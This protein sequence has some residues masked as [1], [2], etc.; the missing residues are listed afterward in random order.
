M[1]PPAWAVTPLCCRSPSVQTIFRRQ[2]SLFGCLSRARK[3]FQASSGM[4]EGLSGSLLLNLSCFH[5]ARQNC[6]LILISSG[7]YV[8][9]T[10][11]KSFVCASAAWAMPWFQ[12][13][14]LTRESL[15]LKSSAT[16]EWTCGK[17]TSRTDKSC[18]R[19][20]SFGPLESPWQ[21]EWST[22]L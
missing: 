9:F 20:G 10:H 1:H 5:Q 15:E 14:R 7:V 17:S 4:F 19:S 13:C 12:T 16:S 8:S 21:I 22:N 2:L 18:Q 11:H 6:F 3:D